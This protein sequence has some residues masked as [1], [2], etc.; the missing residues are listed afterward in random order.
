M[1]HINNEYGCHNN[2]CY[3]ETCTAVFRT[4]LRDR[5]QTIEALNEAWGT[6]FWSMAYSE[7]EEITLPNHTISF[8]NPAC[9]LDYRRFMNESL[10]NIYRAEIAAVQQTGAK[11]PI[12]TN[13]LFGNKS[14]DYFQWAHE[15]DAVA[16]DLYP[17]PCQGDATWRESAF[18]YDLTRS[19]GGHGRFSSWNKQPPRSTGAASTSSNRRG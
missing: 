13:F 14:I 10:L 1:W 11:R 19:Q 5:Y 6:A 2:E 8:Y 18:W 12:A 17:D 15:G 4:W 16:I 7:W 3:C 9:G